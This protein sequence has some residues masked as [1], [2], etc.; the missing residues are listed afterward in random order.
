[1]R[2]REIERK[3]RVGSAKRRLEQL[4][5]KISGSRVT[6]IVDKKLVTS[7]AYGKAVIK[8]M[9]KLSREI[10]INTK[11]AEP[12]RKKT[13]KSLP[14][15]IAKEITHEKLYT[16]TMLAGRWHCSTSRL[17]Y[18][19]SHQQGLPYLKIHGRILYRIEDILDYERVSI[20]HPQ[21]SLQKKIIIKGTS[22]I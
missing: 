5:E 16:D 6:K 17:Q 15:T 11:F 20:V 12:L 22:F 2:Q 19:R 1:M 10:S 7:L 21:D 18:W 14:S 9:S 13:T 3:Q 4:E 8:E